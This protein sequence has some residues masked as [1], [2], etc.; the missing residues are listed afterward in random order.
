M[1][2]KVR[3]APTVTVI[4]SVGVCALLVLTTLT[5]QRSTPTALL[6]AQKQSWDQ[7]EARLWQPQSRAGG[8]NLVKN[9]EMKLKQIESSLRKD[10]LLRGTQMAAVQPHYG[11]GAV[12][13]PQEAASQLRVFHG[14]MLCAE[15][16]ESCVHPCNAFY[17]ITG[18]EPPEDCK[19]KCT[20]NPHTFY[21]DG[22]VICTVRE[23][24]ARLGGTRAL[25]L[26][27]CVCVC[28]CVCVSLCESVCV[29]R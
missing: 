14:R 8:Q 6:A 21:K 5:V 29:D 10:H 25:Y 27:A 9:G 19:C 4:V 26:A 2:L 15:G 12:E 20:H 28:V 16:E 22:S 23:S 17:T 18:E 13:S 7:Q 3:D 24:C 1:H 11:L